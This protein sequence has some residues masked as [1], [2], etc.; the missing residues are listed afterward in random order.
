[1]RAIDNFVDR[2]MELLRDQSAGKPSS[3]DVHATSGSRHRRSHISL[4]VTLAVLLVLR[5]HGFLRKRETAAIYCCHTGSFG[6]F[7]FPLGQ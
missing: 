3:S 2:P 1:M 6:T 4:T 7:K 5:P